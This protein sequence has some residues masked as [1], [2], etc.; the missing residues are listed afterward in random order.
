MKSIMRRRFVSSHYHKDL[1]RKLQCLTQGSMSVQDYYKEMKIV[2]IRANVEEDRGA[3]MIRFIGCLKIEIAEVLE[4]Q[5]YIEIKDLQLKSKSS[6]KFVSSSR[7]S[8]RSNW[9][10]NIIVTNPKEDVIP[11]YSNSHPKGKI[12]IDASYRSCDIKCFRCQGIGHIAFQCPN[13]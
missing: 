2:T 6:S 12:N 11:K 4:L 9:K 13:K 1:H 10:N 7:S 5:H 3:T 8:W